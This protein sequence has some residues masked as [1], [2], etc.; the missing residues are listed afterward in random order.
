MFDTH[1]H[2]IFSTDSTMTLD[3]VVKKQNELAIGAVLT[4]HI[5][6]D[7]PGPDEFSFVPS[8][9]F[10]KYMPY[11]NDKLLL[12]VE[13]GL[14]TQ[15]VKQNIDFVKLADF[16][17]IIGSIHVVC[18]YDIYYADY[19]D[20]MQSKTLAYG[21]YFKTMLENIQLFDD[22]DTL[23]HIDYICRNA[24]YTDNELY[25]NEFSDEIDEIFK[26]IIN[27]GKTIELNT[28]RLG[29]KASVETLLTIYKRYY[30][31]GGRYITIGSDAHTPS[32]IGA[33]FDIAADFADICKLTPVYFKNRQIQKI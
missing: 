7:F 16:D 31:L 32:A 6:F 24:P 30:E 23:G 17:M 14:Q 12:G 2:T 22:F 11:R 10:E 9:Y 15:T 3:E 27:K 21:T 19:F 25:Y 8:E 26:F 29:N 28:R 4:E 5:D 1:M 20:Q 18:G 13:V 33:C